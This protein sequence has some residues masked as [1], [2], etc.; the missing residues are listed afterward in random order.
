MTRIDRRRF[1]K[2]SAAVGAALAFSPLAWAQGVNEQLN[3]GVIGL[4]W[5]GGELMKMF[6]KLPNVRFAA[7]CDV[8]QELLEK[9]AQD[10]PAQRSTPTY[11][12]SWMIKMLMR[13]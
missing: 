4:G 10:K 13:S 11:E 3:L 12:S 6:S 7:L 1:L 8:D 2:H 5:R 9:A